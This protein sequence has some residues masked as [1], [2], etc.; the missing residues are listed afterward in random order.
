MT[1]T[2]ELL[3]A[4][5][6]FNSANQ[7][8]ANKT[9]DF[10]EQWLKDKGLEVEVLINEGYKML[11][12]TVGEGEQKIIFNGHVDVVSGAPYQFK[13]EVKDGK[14]Y[15]RGTADM[16]G[17]LSAM[18]AA[19]T[20]L[21]TLDLGN[22]SVQLHIVSDEETGGNFCT[23]Y[24]VDN[25]YLGDFAICGEPTQLGVGYKAK[26][27]LQMDMF[28][29]GKPA[30]GSRP[31]EGDNAII[32][33][34]KTYEAIKEL[35]FAKVSSDLY[36]AP[37]I[38]LAKILGGD[39]YNKVPQKCEMNVDIRYLPEQSSEEILEEIKEI[40]DANVKIHYEAVPVNNDLESKPMQLL[41]SCIEAATHSSPKVFGQHGTSDAAYYLKYDVPAIEFGPSGS[42]WHGE[43]EYV[44]LQSLELYKTI[45]VNFVQ[46]FSRK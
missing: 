41:L 8:M 34:F 6:E 45:L 4:L 35:P 13:P 12:C 26:G 43:G 28:F 25:G 33:A 18:M 46:S 19:I 1:Q 11:V 23:S 5:I 31:W 9:I 22:T 30:H 24:L 29:E 2:T 3:E 14:M 39:A 36:D 21:S 38:N 15:G 37:S 10:C 40:T 7:A 17:G 44:E 27:V 32:K 20:E 16:K 42:D